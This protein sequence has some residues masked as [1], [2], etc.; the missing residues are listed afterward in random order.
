MTVSDVNN[1]VVLDGYTVNPGDNPWDGLARLGSLTVHDRTPPDRVVERCRDADIVLSNKTPLL[2]ESLGQL[3]RL[4]FIAELATGYDNLDV[5]TAGRFGIPVANV[6]EYGTDSVAQHTLALLLEL[7]NRVALH[8]EAVSAGEWGSSPDFSFC[9]APLTE[10]AGLKFG[11][12]GFGRIGRRVGELARA[13]GM[14]LLA[15][16]PHPERA[17]DAPP[18]TWMELPELF[19]ESDVISLHCPSTPGN[20]GFVNDDLL[21]RMKRGAFFINTSRGRLVNEEDLARALETGRIGGAALDVVSREPI[22]TGNPLLTSRNCLITPHIAWASLAARRR[23]T[24]VAV[25]NVEAYMRGEPVNIVNSRHLDLDRAEAR[26]SG[27]K[28]EE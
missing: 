26:R 9:K 1:I 11:I 10:L 16:T 4:K 23:L 18:V 22:A 14:E 6:P 13:F 24:A 5:E 27:A 28:A 25:S 8:A 19:A 2:A 15:Y 20:A 3:P 7:S 12:V 21:S 17:P